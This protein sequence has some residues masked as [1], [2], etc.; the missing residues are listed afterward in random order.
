MN[1]FNYVLNTPLP[2]GWG[3]HARQELSRFKVS[4]GWLQWVVPH[5]SN[6]VLL[7]SPVSYCQ[8]HLSAVTL[9]Y[10]FPVY[11]MDYTLE[12]KVRLW[13]YSQEL[14]VWH[15]FI[16]LCFRFYQKGLITYQCWC[17]VNYIKMKNLHENKSSALCAEFHMTSL[18]ITTFLYNL[19]FL[20]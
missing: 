16:L 19:K 13:L 2:H 8:A 3:Q 1:N 15:S 12:T 6:P 7:Y 20:L 5:S 9:V 14:N 18:K 17:H 11:F 4:L 10:M